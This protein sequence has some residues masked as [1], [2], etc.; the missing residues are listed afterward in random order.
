MLFGLTSP[1]LI[2]SRTGRKI[3]PVRTLKIEYERHTGRVGYAEP[4][5][6]HAKSR[7]LP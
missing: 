4:L 3:L 5:C 6:G 2:L 1:E 7:L